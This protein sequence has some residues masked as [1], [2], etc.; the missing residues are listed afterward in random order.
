MQRCTDLNGTEMRA[1]GEKDVEQM[2]KWLSIALCMA[3]VMMLAGAAQAE[4]LL[5]TDTA[6][7]LEEA[8]QFPFLAQTNEL[9]ANVRAE[10]STKSAKV[11]RLER[12]TELTVTG[13]EIGTGG[14]LFYQVVLAD[15][16]EGFIRSDL[17]V[18]SEAVRAQAAANP[19]PQESEYQIIGN[20]NSKKYHQ[21]YCRS[22]PSQKNRVYFASSDEAEEAGY[23][24]CQNC[25]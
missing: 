5:I 21:P 13:A 20:K 12:G 24:H 14:E 25:D 2:K 16:T 11:G 17:L 6:D 23:T 4:G 9:A 19:A 7:T 3:L 1:A 10:A 15:G 8:A 18:E 22:L